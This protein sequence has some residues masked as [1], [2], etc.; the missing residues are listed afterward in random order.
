MASHNSYQPLSEE[1]EKSLL[2][3]LLKE[4]NNLYPLNLGMDI[5]CDRFMEDNVFDDSTIW[6]V[7]TRCSLVL[8]TSLPLPNMSS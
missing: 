2:V 5:V 3:L 7:Q 1:N 8:A 6:T 4:L